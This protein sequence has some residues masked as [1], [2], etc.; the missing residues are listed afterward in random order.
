[1]VR[2]CCIVAAVLVLAFCASAQ[3]ATIKADY[4]FEN[5]LASSVAG[6]PNLTNAAASPCDFNGPNSF[7]KLLVG[8]RKIPVLHF[9]RD[10]GVVGPAYP[11]ISKTS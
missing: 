9:Q 2:I 7:H 4:R 10:G 3:A 8:T 5:R 1:M 6:A 11:L